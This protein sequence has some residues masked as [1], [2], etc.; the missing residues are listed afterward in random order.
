MGTKF[1][2]FDCEPITLTS[3]NKFYNVLYYEHCDL[4]RAVQ[5][6]ASILWANE[7]DK[8]LSEL[9]SHVR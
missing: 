2:S 5:I 8:E 6:R 1:D 4:R 7:K 9:L 3:I